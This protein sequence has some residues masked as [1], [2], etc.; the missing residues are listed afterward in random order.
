MAYT[1]RIK[2]TAIRMMLPP[3]NTPLKKI[4]ET[5]G[6]PEGT[7]KKWRQELRENG[8]SMPDSDPTPDKWSSKDKFIIVTETMKLNEAELSEYCRK[9]GLYEAQVKIWQENCM[10]AN[11]NIPGQIAELM[12]QDKITQREL[13]RVK[14]ELLR[15]DST[16]AETAALLVLRKKAEAIWGSSDDEED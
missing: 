13:K 15:K 14:K 9:N 12:Q 4:G 8:H 11:G 7:L 1:R 6:I 2:E 16:L 10:N 5:L 3:E